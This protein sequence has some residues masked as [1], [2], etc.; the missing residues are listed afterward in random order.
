M[1][2]NE[3]L[4]L[5]LLIDQAVKFFKWNKKELK[6]NIKSSV[7][8]FFNELLELQ[9][10]KKEL[11]SKIASL[12]S[13]NNEYLKNNQD[14]KNENSKLST[15]INNLE[16]RLKK[17]NSDY[18]SI[19]AKNKTFKK[20]NEQ[21]Q[22]EYEE[23]ST[24]LNFISKLL[25]APSKTNQNLDHFQSVLKNDF[26]KFANKESSLA[27]EAKA[28]LMLQTIEKKLKLIVNF[29]S[30]YN[31][32]IIAIGGGFS[33]GKSAFVNSFLQNKKIKLPIGINPV[34]AIPTYIIPGES[35]KIKGYSKNGGSID[36]DNAFYENLSH[37]FVKSFNFN[38][39]EIM[40]FMAIE[41]PMKKIDKICFIDTPGY[42]P[43]DVDGGFTSQDKTTASEFLSQANSLIWMLG[44]D[45][46]GTISASDLNFLEQL[47]TDN[48]KLY[49]VANKADLRPESDIEEIIDDIEES[50]EDY[51]IDFS[52]ISAFSSNLQHEYMNRKMSLFDFLKKENKNLRTPKKI[53]S[54]I[55]KIFNM[56][57]SALTKD[58]NNQKK[59][60]SQIHSLELD[61]L[62]SGFDSS[63]TV[64]DKRIEDLKSKFKVNK[65]ETSLTKMLS[66]KKTII[67]SLN[68][69]FK[70]IE[71]N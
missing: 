21:L 5:N 66:V 36:M 50:L 70:G 26:L 38:L 71:A 17:I 6:R 22:S 39:K 11:D 49:I 44:L 28:I 62:E 60:M 1:D 53:T 25:S 23:V 19:K 7:S 65:L 24:K 46:N 45:S 40:P 33:S 52:G 47:D 51:D 20:E 2:N 12:T 35:N 48:K 67:E 30:I 57:N 31:K 56:Y 59:I 4:E 15:Q 8:N 34:T 9:E 3:Y 43:S 42:N 14:L 37:D 55:E 61:L 16:G 41:T 58:I 68:E 32:N 64:I 54:D 10:L 29:S 13:R 69:I 18:K 63:L 27:E